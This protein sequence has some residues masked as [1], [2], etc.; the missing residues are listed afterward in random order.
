MPVERRLVGY[1]DEVAALIAGR[2]VELAQNKLGILMRRISGWM[3]GHGY[4]V[5]LEKIEVVLPDQKKYRDPTLR[6]ISIGGLTI[7]SKPAAKYL[8]LMLHSRLNFFEHIKVAVDKAAIG[9]SALSRLMAHVGGP[10]STRSHL[11]MGATQSVLLYG[12]EV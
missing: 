6:P 9:V 8:A 10:M 5:A 12:A 7:E 2:T 1:A 11:F 4:S 3:A